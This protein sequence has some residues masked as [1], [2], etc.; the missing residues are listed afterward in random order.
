MWRSEV[1]VSASCRTDV[2]LANVGFLAQK[3]NQ[4]VNPA[5]CQYELFDVLHASLMGV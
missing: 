4:N 5:N 3:R 1:A 2:P